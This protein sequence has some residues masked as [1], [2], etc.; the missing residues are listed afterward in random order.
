MIEGLRRAAKQTQKRKGKW[1][2]SGGGSGE[3]GR[4]K[5]KQ[6]KFAALSD[7][8]RGLIDI[9]ILYISQRMKVESFVFLFS[10][11]AKKAQGREKRA[12]KE[13]VKGMAETMTMSSTYAGDYKKQTRREK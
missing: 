12:G 5:D 3:R 2:K 1:E 4:R 13:W 8:Y 6:K 7:A 10:L 11:P 9:C